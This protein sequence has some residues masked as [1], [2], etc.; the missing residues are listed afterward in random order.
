[1]SQQVSVFAASQLFQANIQ[2]QSR[3][4][5]QMS[6]TW[7]FK[8]FHLNFFINENAIYLYAIYLLI[9]LLVI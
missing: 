8:K 7:M 6:E 1:M 4:N 9:T 5:N 2:S 3:D